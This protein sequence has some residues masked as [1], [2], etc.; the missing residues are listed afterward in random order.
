VSSGFSIP[1]NCIPLS[2]SLC[3]G[4]VLFANPRKRGMM[5]NWHHPFSECEYMH[6]AGNSDTSQG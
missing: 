5:P 3:Q 4:R 2:D 1:G 6:G